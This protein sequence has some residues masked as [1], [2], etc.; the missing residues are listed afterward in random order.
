MCMEH[1]IMCKCGKRNASFIFKDEI[2]PPEI[3]MALYCPECSFDIMFDPQSMLIDNGWT[4]QYDMDVAELYAQKLPYQHS[5]K[6]SPE[7]LFDEGYATWR[8]IYPD[9]HIDSARERTELAAL[10]RVDPKKYLKELKE[11]SIRRM[12]CLK[13]EGWRKAHERETV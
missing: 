7:M 12:E 8:G 6:N 4:I 5:P 3:I 10:A 9:D 2:M 11:W 13:R 1:K